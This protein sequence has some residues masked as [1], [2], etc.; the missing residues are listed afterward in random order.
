MSTTTDLSELAAA[1]RNAHETIAG[2]RAILESMSEQH[3]TFARHARNMWTAFYL[4]EQAEF[5]VAQE[6]RRE[7]VREARRDRQQ[8]DGDGA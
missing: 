1:G 3:P 5:D 7:R 2:L 4:V 8:D 6:L